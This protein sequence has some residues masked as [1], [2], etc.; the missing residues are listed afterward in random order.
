DLRRVALVERMRDVRLGCGRPFDA[1]RTP[2]RRNCSQIFAPRTEAG[3]RRPRPSAPGLEVLVTLAHLAT[4]L[5]VLFA[6]GEDQRPEP[7][8]ES[9]PE[10]EPPP[11]ESPPEVVTTATSPVVVTGSVVPPP[12]PP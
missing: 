12:P 3:V 1:V 6:A 11:C 10:P 9:E 8:P 2:Y 5:Q 4:P 7:E